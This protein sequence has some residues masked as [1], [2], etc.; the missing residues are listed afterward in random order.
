MT[1]GTLNY[2]G[3]TGSMQVS[4]EDNCLYGRVLLIDDLIT[5]E[6]QTEEEVL[7]AFQE[8][9]DHYLRTCAEQGLSANV[10]PKRQEALGG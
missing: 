10:P 2:K 1:E 4:I 5:Y 9:V 3:Y 7:T 6:G 8:S